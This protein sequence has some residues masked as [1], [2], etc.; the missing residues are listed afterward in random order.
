[1][2]LRI[3]SKIFTMT[4]KALRGSGSQ[5]PLS[6]L[7]TIRLP[8]FLWVGNQ[9]P[10]GSSEA[11]TKLQSDVSWHQSHPRAR[12]GLETPFLIRLTPVAGELG[13]AV[14]KKPQFL[15]ASASPSGLASSQTGSRVPVGNVMERVGEG[16]RE[17]MSYIDIDTDTDKS[18]FFCLPAECEL[19]EGRKL[20]CPPPISI[21]QNSVYPRVGAHCKCVCV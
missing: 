17:A 3:K 5:T 15:S 6:D 9:E 21:A 10:P 12:V 16:E 13:L 14:C 4:C 18:L 20:F 2:M 19:S 11:L 1:M 7:K 8:Q